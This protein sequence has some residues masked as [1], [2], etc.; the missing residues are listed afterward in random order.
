MLG[1]RKTPHTIYLMYFMIS[2]EIK[3]HFLFYL[4]KTSA[5]KD[6]IHNLFLEVYFLFKN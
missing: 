2:I 4:N 1:L 6:K 5:V 3:I